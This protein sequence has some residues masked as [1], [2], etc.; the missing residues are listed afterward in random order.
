LHQAL[1]ATDGRRH[2]ALVNPYVD[3]EWPLHAHGE[4]QRTVHVAF[5]LDTHARAAHSAR[6]FDEIC[7]RKAGLEGLPANR[8][9]ALLDHSVPRIVQD[10]PNGVDSVRGGGVDFVLHE[11]RAV[12]QDGDRLAGS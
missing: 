7:S 8:L 6:D 2:L 5:G 10:D 12:A 4:R 3:D 1:I 9:H 11:H